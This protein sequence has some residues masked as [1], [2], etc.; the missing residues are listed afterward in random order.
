MPS[1]LSNFPHV[2]QKE[3][4]KLERD[5]TTTNVRTNIIKN[6]ENRFIPM[7]NWNGIASYEV[8]QPAGKIITDFKQSLYIFLK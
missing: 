5:Q 7:T 4:K 1:H 2:P 3:V 8:E 6:L